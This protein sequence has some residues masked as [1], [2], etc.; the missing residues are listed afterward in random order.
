MIRINSYE[1][2]PG[3]ISVEVASDVT[4]MYTEISSV[5]MKKI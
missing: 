2:L 5:R 1:F 4:E 3:L